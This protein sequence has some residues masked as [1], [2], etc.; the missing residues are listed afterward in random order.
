MVIKMYCINH[1][2]EQPDNSG[3]FGK[4]LLKL[5]RMGANGLYGDSNSSTLL[6][7]PSSY[8]YVIN[9]LLQTYININL[10]I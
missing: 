9:L 5:V 1:P 2:M 10:S 3:L 4:Q 7:S 8:H 6:Y